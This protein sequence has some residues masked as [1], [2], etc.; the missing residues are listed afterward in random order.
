MQAKAEQEPPAP[1][2]YAPPP[3]PVPTVKVQT[4]EEIDSAF[5]GPAK[6]AKVTPAAKVIRTGSGGVTNIK[7]MLSHRSSLREALVLKEIL[8]KPISLRD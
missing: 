3:L 2:A 7:R 6:V 5:Y 1:V 4:Q 8:E